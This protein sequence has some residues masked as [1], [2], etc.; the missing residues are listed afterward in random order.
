MAF[1][2]TAGACVTYLGVAGVV[3]YLSLFG[4]DCFGDFEK[5]AE[6]RDPTFYGRSDFVDNHMIYPMISYQGWNLLYTL[7]NADQ[8]SWNMVGHHGVTG[9]LAYFGLSPYLHCYGLFFF[10]IAELTN[11]PLT[12][13][14]VFK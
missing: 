9:L 5:S 8:F 10:G 14:D 13:V 2:I 6:G 7:V 1:M 4:V 11:I 3:G 12:F